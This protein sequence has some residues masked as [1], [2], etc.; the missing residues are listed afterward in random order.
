MEV[1]ADGFG[2]FFAAT[3][4]FSRNFRMIGSA[5][6]LEWHA[7]FY[8][9]LPSGQQFDVSERNS[10]KEIRYKIYSIAYRKVFDFAF[11]RKHFSYSAELKT[12]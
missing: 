10:I 8:C 3:N 9:V 11:Y 2:A 7:N 6:K 12:S 4:C 5:R 1:A